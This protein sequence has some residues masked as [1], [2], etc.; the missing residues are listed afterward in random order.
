MELCWCNIAEWKNYSIHRDVFTCRTMFGHGY[1]ASANTNIPFPIG[2][3]FPLFHLP[4][5]INTLPAN[6]AGKIRA[7]P[8]IRRWN[9]LDNV[10]SA[11]KISSGMIN[12][13]Y[14]GNWFTLF[15]ISI[16]SLKKFTW[17]FLF[18]PLTYAK[19]ALIIVS[20]YVCVYIHWVLIAPINRCIT[21]FLE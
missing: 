12:V 18:D 14:R 8:S 15:N 9:I 4:G 10:N 2:I 21:I 17:V 7:R 1:A 20:M 6:R 3:E 13:T 19:S 11:L 5:K 16:L